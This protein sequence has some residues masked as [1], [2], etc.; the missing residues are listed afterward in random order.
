MTDLT[1]QRI[2]VAPFRA[3]I[4]VRQLW[5]PGYWH[6]RLMLAVLPAADAPGL[7]ERLGLAA[8]DL[9][10]DG[11]DRAPSVVLGECRTVPSAYSERPGFTGYKS[12][13][14]DSYD[15]AEAARLTHAL[16]L[17]QRR[18]AV[19]DEERQRAAAAREADQAEAGAAYL[20]RQAGRAESEQRL[21]RRLAEFD[22]NGPA[23]G[24]PGGA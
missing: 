2:D 24:L 14:L 5:V 11:E 4:R 21:A 7:A 16:S 19:E 18:A 15:P 17:P 23:R 10:R 13:P 22:G 12:L 8:E 20:R 6:S 1:T 3:G 9:Y